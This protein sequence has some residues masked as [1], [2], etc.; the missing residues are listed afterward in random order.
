MCIV[1]FFY[2]YKRR[3]LFIRIFVDNIVNR[4]SFCCSAAFRDF[5]HLKPITSPFVCKDEYIIMCA[6]NKHMSDKIVFAGCSSCNT[7]AASRL[8][9][10][11]RYREPF[12]ETAVADRNHNFFFS[13]HIFNAKLF[14]LINNLGSAVITVFLFHCNQLFLYNFHLELFIFQNRFQLF[15][16]FYGLTIFI[17]HLFTFEPG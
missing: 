2:R 14:R 7:L 10:I 12:D 3:N 17:F 16:E 11:T 1:K 9:S 4:F 13:N 8:P 5:E 15:D 6:C